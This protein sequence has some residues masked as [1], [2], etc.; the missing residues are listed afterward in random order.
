MLVNTKENSKMKFITDK[1]KKKISLNDK[2][3]IFFFPLLSFASLVSPLTMCDDDACL[4][5]NRRS[6]LIYFNK[7]QL[8][9]KFYYYFFFF[10]VNL[11][12]F[13]ILQ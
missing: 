7:F 12:K 5:G 11:N 9:T 1:K 10:W 13:I 8:D 4:N 3:L 6:N 2:K